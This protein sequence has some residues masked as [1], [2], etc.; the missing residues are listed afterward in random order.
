VWQLFRAT[1]SSPSAP[2]RD[3]GV[4]PDVNLG[5][6]EAHAY[7]RAS[8]AELWFLST[9]AGGWDIYMAPRTLT[10]FGE[11]QPQTALN[12]PEND[13]QPMITEDGNTLLLASDRPGGK[14]AVDLYIATR[15]TTSGPFDAPKPVA[16]IN[17]PSTEYAGYL[18]ADRCRLY[19]SSDRENDGLHHLFMAERPPPDM[20]SP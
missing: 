9:R 8:N 10:G 14:G 17:T 12:S 15:T 20:A 1:R 11:A 7:Y 19:F 6:D 16:E 18:S 3:L 2:W 4:V 13:F 5:P